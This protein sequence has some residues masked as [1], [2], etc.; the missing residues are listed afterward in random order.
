MA[1]PKFRVLSAIGALSL[2]ALQLTGCQAVSSLWGSEVLQPGSSVRLLTVF[3]GHASLMLNPKNITG[4]RCTE[5]LSCVEAFATDQ[6]IYYRFET[7]G[8]AEALDKAMGGASAR[9]NFIVIEYLE[10]S[11]SMATRARLQALVDDVHA[12]PTLFG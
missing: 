6:A 2:A 11:M 9:S 12:D 8:E 5:A 7:I 10:P 4:A 3:S 1:R